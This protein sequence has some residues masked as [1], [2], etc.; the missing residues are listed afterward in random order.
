[1]LLALDIGNTTITFGLFDGKKQGKTGRVLRLEQLP[2]AYFTG[3]SEVAVASVVPRLDPIVRLLIKRRLKI[4][5]HFIAY[6]DIPLEITLKNKS[7]IGVDRLVDAYAAYKLYGGP[8]IVVDFGTATT[9]C[10]VT[11]DGKYLGGAIAPGIG[12]SRDALHEK[13]A[14]LPL[15]SVRAVERAI[16]KSTVAAMD[17]GIYLGY[18]GLINELVKR[19]KS[20]MGK[21]KAQAKEKAVGKV[22]E[23]DKDKIKVVATGGFAKLLS[24]GVKFDII[25]ETLTLKGINLLCPKN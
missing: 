23:K 15:V 11:G 2:F 14:K 8:A 13:T 7:E 4:V 5:P 17:A 16:G 21:N 1:M 3:V 20:E 25:D 18:V 12:I 22:K 10:A 6:K 24:R 9:F 19:L